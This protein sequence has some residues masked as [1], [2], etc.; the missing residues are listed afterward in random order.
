MKE[1]SSHVCGRFVAGKG[2]PA[3]LVNPATEEALASASTE[4]I[5][6]GEVL[7][8]ARDRGG[9]ALRAMTFKQRGEVLRAMSRSIHAKRCRPRP[10]IS[11]IAWRSTSRWGCSVSVVV[12]RRALPRVAPKQ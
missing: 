3:T 9:P 6:F 10:R 8:F 4:G 5:D 12:I 1:L 7:A 2:R 11:S